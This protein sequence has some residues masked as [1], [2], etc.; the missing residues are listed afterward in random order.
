MS[1]TLPPFPALPR[2][3][4]RHSPTAPAWHRSY[5]PTSTVSVNSHSPGAPHSAPSRIQ[6]VAK[7][8]M[9]FRG[10]RAPSCFTLVLSSTVPRLP[11]QPLSAAA[12]I[13]SMDSAART[14][15]LELACRLHS[16]SAS[17]VRRQATRA[18]V[19]NV[20]NQTSPVECPS[21]SV[22]PYACHHPSCTCASQRVSASN[23]SSRIV[24][25]RSN[26]ASILAPNEAVLRHPERFDLEWTTNVSQ[27]CAP[28][29]CAPSRT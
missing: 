25:S 13:E 22:R 1:S 11:M 7:A 2:S 23:R 21:P 20:L 14:K 5:F 18:R 27:R 12:L 4:I 16:A 9:R 3:G 15:A 6:Q 10:A 8:P 24:G 19:R 17:A 28:L 26:S 29:G